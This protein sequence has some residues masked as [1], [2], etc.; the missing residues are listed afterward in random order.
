MIRVVTCLKNI[1]FFDL[2]FKV[3]ADHWQC[4][5]YFLTISP[6]GILSLILLRA[7]LAACWAKESQST[8]S[9]CRN[10]TTRPVSPMPRFPSVITHCALL[11]TLLL[12]S[13]TY[14]YNCLV[15]TMSYH[16][17]ATYYRYIYTLAGLMNIP[18]RI[19]P[20][21]RLNCQVLSFF[22]NFHSCLVFGSL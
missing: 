2:F 16:A 17:L 11:F 4:M 20:H 14:N 1:P 18:H 9:C 5:Y 13:R 8:C 19:I 15:L 6:P 7:S 12:L 21:R 10:M 22:T 3:F